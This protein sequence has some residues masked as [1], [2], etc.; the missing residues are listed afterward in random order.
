MFTF[1]SCMMNIRLTITSVRIPA[2]PIQL[3]AI[4]FTSQVR[5]RHSDIHIYSSVRCSVSTCFG[6]LLAKHAGSYT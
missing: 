4:F 6:F 3:F 2:E 1:S 5:L